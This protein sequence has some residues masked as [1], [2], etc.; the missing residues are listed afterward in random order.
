MLE[1]GK[2]AQY[3]PLQK[4]SLGFNFYQALITENR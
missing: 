3:P 2:S 1:G 4:P